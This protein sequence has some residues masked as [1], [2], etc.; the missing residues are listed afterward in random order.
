ML[1]VTPIGESLGTGGPESPL[2]ISPEIYTHEPH[3]R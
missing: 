2:E 3:L 1:N